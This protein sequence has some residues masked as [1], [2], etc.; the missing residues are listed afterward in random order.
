MQWGLV[1]IGAGI[2]AIPSLIRMSRKDLDLVTI[3]ITEPVV[4]RQLGIVSYAGRSLSPAA[5]RLRD[6]ARTIMRRHE[7]QLAHPVPL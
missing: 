4:S 3:P 6:V 2:A 5:L 1:G 7:R